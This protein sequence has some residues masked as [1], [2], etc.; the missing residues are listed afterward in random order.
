MSS[1][2]VGISGKSCR[3]WLVSLGVNTEVAGRLDLGIEFVPLQGIYQCHPQD[4]RYMVGGDDDGIGSVEVQM[5]E[6][7]AALLQRDGVSLC[8]V[9]DLE[10]I[11]E[12]RLV[13]SRPAPA[14]HRC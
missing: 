1:G 11:R 6:D 4:Q 14:T 5:R 12:D 9:L 13:S 10:G 3:W 7:E 8:L 2:L